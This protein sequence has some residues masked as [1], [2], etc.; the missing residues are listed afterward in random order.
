[1]PPTLMLPPIP[2]QKQLQTC[3]LPVFLHLEVIELR[4]SI[5]VCVFVYIQRVE[6]SYQQGQLLLLEDLYEMI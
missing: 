3:L 6:V 1:M 2:D 5:L 4:S